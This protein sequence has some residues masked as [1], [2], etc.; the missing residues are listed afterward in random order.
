MVLA[1]SGTVTVTLNDGTERV[2]SIDGTP[3]SYAVVE[4]AGGDRGVLHVDV[5]PGVDVYSFTFG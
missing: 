3:R 5:S 2:L 1:G 4:H